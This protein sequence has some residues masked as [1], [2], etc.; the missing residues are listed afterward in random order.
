LKL[1]EAASYAV[2]IILVIG[3]GLFLFSLSSFFYDIAR[4]FNTPFYVTLAFFGIILLLFAT[5]LAKIFS[6]VRW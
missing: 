5:F 6:K 4:S 1:I 3:L 2:T